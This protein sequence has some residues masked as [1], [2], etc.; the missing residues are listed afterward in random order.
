MSD[1]LPEPEHRLHL[2]HVRENAMDEPGEIEAFYDRCSDLMRALLEELA[3][4]PDQPRAFPVIEDAMGWPRRRISSVLGGVFTVRT[5]RLRRPP[6][7]PLPRRAPGRL[8]PLGAVDG[9]GAGGDDPTR[10]GLTDGSASRSAACTLCLVPRLPLILII[11]GLSAAVFSQLG[12]VEGVASSS[13]TS[14][15]SVRSGS[16]GSRTSRA[17][18][19]CRPALCG[20]ICWR[21]PD[22]LV[23]G[24]VAVLLALGTAFVVWWLVAPPYVVFDRAG[25]EVGGTGPCGSP[26]PSWS[27]RPSAPPLSRAPRE[28][29]ASRRVGTVGVDRAPAATS[30]NDRSSWR[31]DGGMPAQLRSGN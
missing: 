21:W 16:R 3:R 11:A 14:A 22:R 4:T 31:V 28:R 9:S 2:E 12:S 1:A 29:R 6:P 30:A 15:C 20:A 17:G 13:T 7:L 24:I 19:G 18:W 23:A 26:A 5:R 25:R 27:W 8:T 10:R